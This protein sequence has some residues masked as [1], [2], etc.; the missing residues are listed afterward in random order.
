M[1]D[2]VIAKTEEDLYRGKG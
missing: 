1:R 2:A